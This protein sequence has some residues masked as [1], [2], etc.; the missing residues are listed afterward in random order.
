MNQLPPD[1]MDRYQDKLDDL[2]LGWM[3]SEIIKEEMA[4]ERQMSEVA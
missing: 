2:F 1:E 3:E 4:R